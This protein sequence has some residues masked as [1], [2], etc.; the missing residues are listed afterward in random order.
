MAETVAIWLDNVIRVPSPNKGD[1]PFAKGRP[2]GWVLHVNQSVGN[3]DGFFA[4][5]TNIN[6]AQVCPNFQVYRD[7]TI[8]QHLPLDYSPWCQADGNA[9]YAAVETEGF[10]TEPL[11]ASQLASLARIHAAYRDQLGVPDQ[12]ADTVGA[13][14][15]GVHSMGGASW[16]GHACPGTIRASQRLDIILASQAH[17]NPPAPAP[18]PPTV[19]DDTAMY[20]LT[21]VGSATRTT[22]L[23]LD[24]V[25]VL[26]HDGPTVDALVT[27]GVR[28]IGLPSDQFAAVTG[29]LGPIVQ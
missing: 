11:T 27:E 20:L 13:R 16:G 10:D 5:G 6:P 4:G 28:R 17:P 8:H 3:L 1:G 18:V 21:D 22:V 15:V 9:D 23:V 29:R 26:Q 7:G 12:V 2:L 24:G 14:G 19:K 25:P